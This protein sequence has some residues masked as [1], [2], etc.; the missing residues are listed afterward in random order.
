[1]KVINNSS[2]NVVKFKSLGMPVKDCIHKEVKSRLNMG[3]VSYHS[4]HNLL[5]HLL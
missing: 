4:V 3:D 2:E 5:S 1:M